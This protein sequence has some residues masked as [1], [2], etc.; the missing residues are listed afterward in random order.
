MAC[1]RQSL[2]TAFWQGL[3]AALLIVLLPLCAGV[4]GGLANAGGPPMTVK[5]GGHFNVVFYGSENVV[6]AHLI[7][8]VLEEAYRKVGA[9]I[10]F[11][12]RESIGAVLYP[13]KDFFDITKSPS[14]VGAIYDGKI[15]MPAGG[16]VDRTGELER[17]I[18]TSIHTPLSSGSQGAGPR[19]G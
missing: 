17:V 8:L 7:S 12:P 18:S 2:P 10:L 3:L 1:T 19:P 16:L 4:T 14:W 11:W 15:K 9:D 5:R 6:S 13:E